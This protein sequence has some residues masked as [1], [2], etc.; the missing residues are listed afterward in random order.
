MEN[1]LSELFERDLLKLRDEI[2]NFKN[3]ANIW[4]T[5]DGIT[6]SAGTLTLHLLGNLNYT[7]GTLL[8]GTGY[9]RNREQEFSLRDVP[10]AK[11]VA[12]IEST[13][14][15]VKAGLNGID[16]SKLDEIYALDFLGKHSTVWY[17]TMFYGHLNY[18]LGQVNYL[19]RILESLTV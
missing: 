11:L 19:R 9:I 5:T 2:K 4:K 6:N 10:Q 7:V 15:V 3:E 12:D 16:Q 13:I 17:L 8:G 18:H 1:Y 14:E